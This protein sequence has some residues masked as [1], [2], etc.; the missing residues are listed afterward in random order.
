MSPRDVSPHPPRTFQVGARRTF[1][2]SFMV[3]V[4]F[5]SQL[6]GFATNAGGVTFVLAPV[7]LNG[8][9]HATTCSHYGLAPTAFRYEDILWDQN[10]L[11][12]L[13]SS[14]GYT[15]VGKL[16]CCAQ[17]AWCD[18]GTKKCFSTG[19]GQKGYDNIGWKGSIVNISRAAGI[20]FPVPVYSCEARP[21]GMKRR[22]VRK[23]SRRRV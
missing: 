23:E 7:G 22:R 17:A 12:K 5:C 15:T 3:L 14:F 11:Q 2:H 18:K 10:E 1:V 20:G 21:Q 4:F 16:G 8:T 13:S 9:T 6:A 19:F